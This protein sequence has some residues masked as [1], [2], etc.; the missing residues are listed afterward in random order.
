MHLLWSI[1]IGLVVGAIAKALM[2]GK[3]PGGFI[4]TIVLGIAGAMLAGFLGRTMGM[5]RVGDTGPG[6]IASIL[7]AVILLF[8]YRMVTGRGRA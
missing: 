4:I 2:P 8:G 7:G 3:D 6:L 1:I 5:Y